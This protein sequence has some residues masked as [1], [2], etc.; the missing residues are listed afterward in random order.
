MKPE[1]VALGLTTDD[2]SLET[3]ELEARDRPTAP[4]RLDNP[5]ANLIQ[6]GRPAMAA[7]VAFC[8]PD[9]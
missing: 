5:A 4:D 9:Y 7:N 8:R 1:P 2:F 3:L 6:G